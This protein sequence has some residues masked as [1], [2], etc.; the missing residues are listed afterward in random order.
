MQKR[1]PSEANHLT[2]LDIPA[3][4]LLVT[5]PFPQPRK[6]KKNTSKYFVRNIFMGYT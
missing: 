1:S 5:W 4:N 6:K 2:S 3:Y